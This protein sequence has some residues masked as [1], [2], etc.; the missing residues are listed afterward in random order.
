MKPENAACEI[1]VFTF[2]TRRQ[3]W[4]IS[5]QCDAPL[6]NEACRL[7][8]ISDVKNQI[9]LMREKRG[10]QEWWYNAMLALIILAERDVYEAMMRYSAADADMTI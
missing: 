6:I 4:E 3:W 7:K 10:W 9:T 8:T 2:I 5:Y 1:I